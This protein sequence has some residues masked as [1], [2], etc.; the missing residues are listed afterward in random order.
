MQFCQKSCC[1]V[2]RRLLY[3]SRHPGL[4]QPHSVLLLLR[5]GFG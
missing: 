5:R 4:R 2:L 1:I 3:S